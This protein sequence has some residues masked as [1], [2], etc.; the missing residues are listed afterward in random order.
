MVEARWRGGRDPSGPTMPTTM[1]GE[2][3][4]VSSGRAGGGDVRQVLEPN[5]TPRTLVIIIHE[6]AVNQFPRMAYYGGV[7]SGRELSVRALSFVAED[8]YQVRATIDVAG[9]WRLTPKIPS[10]FGPIFAVSDLVGGFHF[11]TQ[12]K[13]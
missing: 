5:R 7:F 11:S 12:K 2:G 13:M 4:R 6:E 9:M 1:V 3:G 10:V 8:P